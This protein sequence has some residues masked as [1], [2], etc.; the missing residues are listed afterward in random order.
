MS[1]PFSGLKQQATVL[2]G[3]KTLLAG[4]LFHAGCLLGSFFNP[5]TKAACSSE[6]LNPTRQKSLL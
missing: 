3:G 4:C 5:E 2:L 1:P 6:A